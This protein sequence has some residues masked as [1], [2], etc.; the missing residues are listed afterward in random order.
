MFGLDLRGL[1]VFR[2]VLGL[3]V[4]MDLVGR[5]G[6][7]VV[8]YTDEG[9]IP[10]DRLLQYLGDWRWS[11]M[12]INGSDEFVRMFFL[13]TAAVAVAVILGYRTRLGVVL[14]WILVL[15]I[16]VRNPY[17]QNGGD[18]FLRLL[19]FW[20][21]FLPLGAV[22]S[23]DVRLL[24]DRRPRMWFASMA[25][26]ALLLQIAFMY[27]FTA[28]LKDSPEWRSDF[29]ALWYSLGA[30]HLTTPFGGWA[31]QFPDVLK[32]LTIGTMAV[33][34]VAPVL[35]FMPFWSSRMRAIAAMFIVG[36]QV[37]ILA[38]LQV[39]LFP[40]I[41]ALCMV[42]VLPSE[43]WNRLSDWGSRIAQLRS[44]AWRDIPMVLKRTAAGIAPQR[45][46]RVSATGADSTMAYA[47]APESRQGP[48]SM[49]GR[50]LTLTAAARLPSN[51]GHDDDRQ[52]ITS[53]L[54][55]NLMVSVFLT[56]VVAWN[57][58]TVSAFTLSPETR[59][60]TIGLGLHQQWNMFAPRPPSTTQWY[61]LAGTLENRHEVNLLPALTNNDIARATPL[62]W[63]RPARI[64]TDYYGDKYWRKYL[65][66]IGNDR[67]AEDQ[68]LLAAY[69]CRTWNAQ[70]T[71]DQRL[72]TVQ[73]ATASES[74]LVGG[75]TGDVLVR[76]LE[77][78]NCT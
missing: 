12:I 33:E 73:L 44:L 28:I 29:S 51:H 38:T 21:M 23:L 35:L 43:F 55:T 64:G 50:P 67:K 15:S 8:H 45:G 11:L 41:G 26:V 68:R 22:W 54:G 76:E 49:T 32:A 75:E 34:V 18:T 57:A 69:A 36:L 39:G 60:A 25:S 1:A 7:A 30:G 6:N 17:V 37:G 59:R 10:R 47:G 53:S 24:R 72:A 16:Q 71:G 62:N 5:W 48:K 56:L 27:W 78:F 40:W 74:I 14:L 58:T 77:L 61:V 66:T 52:R 70:Y 2:I 19:L 42:A 20:A 9:V 31:H 4:L 63:E 13:A 46:W 3:V 65:S